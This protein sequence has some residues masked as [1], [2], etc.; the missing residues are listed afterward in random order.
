MKIQPVRNNSIRRQTVTSLLLE[1]M[2]EISES[3]SHH[4]TSNHEKSNHETSNHEIIDRS[5]ILSYN[6][7]NTIVVKRYNNLYYKF[8]SEIIDKYTHND[9]N[10]DLDTILIDDFIKKYNINGDILKTHIIYK[11]ILSMRHIDKH[12]FLFILLHS[13]ADCIDI[14][15]DINVLIEYINLK[16]IHFAILQGSVIGLSYLLQFSVSIL[17]RQPFY[18]AL[19]SLIGVKPILD[20]WRDA[21][22]TVHYS[23]QITTNTQN[24]WISRMISM[25]FRSIPQLFIQM[26]VLLRYG[27]INGTIIQFTSVIISIISIGMSVA[28]TDRSLDMNTILR[29]NDPHIHG[30]INLDINPYYQY[31][32][33]I[34]FF[35]TYIMM[36]SYS[37]SLLLISGFNLEYLLFWFCFEFFIL[38]LIR[39]YIKNWRLYRVGIDTTI[40]SFFYNIVCYIIIL[41]I[42][43]PILRAPGCLTCKIYIASIIYM[44]LMNYIMIYIAYRYY[45]INNNI[46]EDLSFFFFT[47]RYI[48]MHYIFHNNVL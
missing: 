28:S 22:S 38:F 25:L 10:V 13:V 42:P 31:I 30:Y 9:L 32:S 16:Y 35:S 3:N 21:T 15:L 34:T 6:S 36:K 1:N 48:N 26:Y 39:V 47:G 27:T 20:N 4:E 11:M 7:K 19:T 41:T 23:G 17:T 8:K 29:F 12:R 46:S 33:L 43:A 14:F 44:I 5:E 40:I 2:N 24:R 18:W 37:V 45:T